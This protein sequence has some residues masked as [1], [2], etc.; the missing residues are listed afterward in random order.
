MHE[1][2]RTKYATPE[3]TRKTINSVPP[4][5]L[6]SL[7]PP[8]GLGQREPGACD[9]LRSRGA[10]GQPR[11]G[12][13]AIRGD[14]CS[15][16]RKTPPNRAKSLRLFPGGRSQDPVKCYDRARGPRT[17]REILQKDAIDTA[18][19]GWLGSNEGRLTSSGAMPSNPILAKHE[20][21]ILASVSNS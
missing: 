11:F 17:D 12:V 6:P 9:C 21:S 1:E 19:R 7:Y 5:L 10:R 20:D 8:L 4:I 16:P 3:E 15:W 14:P 18:R 13:L 2:F